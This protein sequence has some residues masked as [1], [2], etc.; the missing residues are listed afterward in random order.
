MADTTT[1]LNPGTGGDVLDESSVQQISG[2]AA[3]RPRVVVGNDQGQLLDPSLLLLA[4]E[5]IIR[6]LRAQT[7]LLQVLTSQTTTQFSLEEAYMAAS[8]LHND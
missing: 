4:L 6:E 2:T 8:E 7:I 5:Q 1:V 3:K